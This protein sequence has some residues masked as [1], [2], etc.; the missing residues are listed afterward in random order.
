MFMWWHVEF[1]LSGIQNLTVSK[2]LK[3]TKELY[4]SSLIT[5]SLKA[6]SHKEI[7]TLAMFLESQP[8]AVRVGCKVGHC[9]ILGQA[10][11]EGEQ[12]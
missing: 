11:K 4:K 10:E 6:I 8:L 3:H 12:C 2:E 1:F 7:T 9:F 5:V